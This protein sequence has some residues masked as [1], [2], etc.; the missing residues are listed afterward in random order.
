MAYEQQLE[1][2]NDEEVKTYFRTQTVYCRRINCVQIFL[3]IFSCATY[4]LVSFVELIQVE[5]LAFYKNAPFM[6]DIW[7]P[8]R[9]EEHMTWVVC[10]NMVIIVQ[11]IILNST[12]QTTFICLMVYATTRFGVLQIRLKKF[13]RVA[14]E[15]NVLSV[16]RDLIVEHQESIR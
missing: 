14:K 8:F 9:R 5:D 11:G 2:Q 7:Y 16:I 1:N 4:V 10:I 6:H 15:G 12:T 3:T 13:D